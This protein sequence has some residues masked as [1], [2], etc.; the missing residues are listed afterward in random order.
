MNETTKIEENK[1]DNSIIN[2]S[3]STG[4]NTDDS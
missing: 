3:N 4:I 2:Q 1:V